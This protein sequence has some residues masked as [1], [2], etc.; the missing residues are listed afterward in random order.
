MRLDS[1][2]RIY[3]TQAVLTSRDLRFRNDVQL[4]YFQCRPCE[5]S[6]NRQLVKTGVP[7]NRNP[8]KLRASPSQPRGLQTPL[9]L[10]TAE[11]LSAVDAA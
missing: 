9:T 5:R 8:H 6:F 4:W 11:G 2:W 3:L 7:G 1:G 10:V